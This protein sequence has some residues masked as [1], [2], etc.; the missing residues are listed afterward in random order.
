MLLHL[1]CRWISFIFSIIWARIPGLKKWPETN[2]INMHSWC[3]QNYSLLQV[4]G[5]SQGHTWNSPPISPPAKCRP[6]AFFQL[7]SIKT[8]SWGI[9]HGC[10]DECAPCR[11]KLQPFFFSF[12]NSLLHRRCWPLLQKSNCFT[13]TFIA[14]NLVLKTTQGREREKNGSEFDS[15]SLFMKNLKGAV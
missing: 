2:C 11:M 7:H 9:S 12:Y 4:N 8:N 15:G 13:I 14:L 3:R 1:W 6:W 10:T 5:W